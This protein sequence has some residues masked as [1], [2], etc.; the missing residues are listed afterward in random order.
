MLGYNGVHKHC[1]SLNMLTRQI[2]TRTISAYPV[3]RIMLAWLFIV[4]AASFFIDGPRVG[5]VTLQVSSGYDSACAVTNGRV[6]CWGNNS[7]GQIGNG[8]MGGN[9]ETPVSVAANKDVVAPGP[10]TC[11]A[12]IPFIGT[13]I[14]SGPSTPGIPPSALAGKQVDKVSVG[15][16]HSCAIANAKVYCWGDNSKGQLGTG[17]TVDSS[18]PLAATV[19]S[20]VAPGPTT[21]TARIPII[22]TC[23]ASGPS[24][25]MKPASALRSKEIIDI[26]AGDG[27]T[28]SLATDGDVACWGEGDDGR[29]GTNNT[30]DTSYPQSIYKVQGSAFY[31]KK[32]IKLARVSDNAMCV[33][34]VDKTAPVQEAGDPYCWGNGMGD[35]IIPNGYTR[36]S[37]ASVT[38]SSCRAG[39]TTTTASNYFDALRPVSYKANQFFKTVDTDGYATAIGAN[40]KIYYW[41]MNGYLATTVN[42][43]S[44]GGGSGGNGLDSGGT[45]CGGGKDHGSPG[46]AEKVTKKTISTVTYKRIGYLTPSG[47][48][49]YDGNGPLAQKSVKTTSGEVLASLLCADITTNVYC[50][51]NGTSMSEGQTGSNYIPKCVTTTVFSIFTQTV[52]EPAPTG[53]QKV[54]TSGWLASRVIKQMDTGNSGFTCALATDGAVACWGVN[55]HGQLGVGDVANRN[56]PIPINL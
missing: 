50:D 29:L 4:F 23:I 12:R 39:T 17:T 47:P 11:T 19:N 13:C 32:G 36:T 33:L 7:D 46:C 24:T 54:S 3:V 15:K 26:A 37:S 52:C 30:A 10:T 16:A 55:N 25:P 49:Y 45:K 53:P 42:K 18:V 40:N 5:A 48:A 9:K 2:D 41:G 21:C 51:A 6:K 35:G 34:A 28:C 20:Y 56:I 27:F 22:G 1:A 31:G 43:V 38:K 8:V 14:A 44:C